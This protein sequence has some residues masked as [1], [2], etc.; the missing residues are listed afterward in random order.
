MLYIIISCNDS[1]VNTKYLTLFIYNIPLWLTLNFPD[2]CIYTSI[3]TLYPP[4]AHAQV[5]F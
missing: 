2:L 4:M 3:Y 1:G 5:I